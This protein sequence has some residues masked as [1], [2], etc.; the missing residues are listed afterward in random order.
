[1]STGVERSCRGVLSD[2]SLSFR[3]LVSCF[4]NCCP[5]CVYSLDYDNK[6]FS[7][8]SRNSINNG[9]NVNWDWKLN[10][11][12]TYSQP[13]S[14]PSP[15]DF[16]P[17]GDVDDP[18]RRDPHTPHRRNTH[19][20]NTVTK[21]FKK[22][23]ESHTVYTRHVNLGFRVSFGMCLWCDVSTHSVGVRHWD[24]LGTVV[25]WRSITKDTVGNQLDV[26]TS[27]TPAPVE[28]PHHWSQSP[29]ESPHH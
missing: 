29:P 15:P 11:V 16:V 17:Y 27:L 3:V 21:E 24:M 5:Y 6:Q 22:K 18:N 13:S 25:M 26:S 7:Y 1:M 28:S 4:Q 19:L 10:D 2:P 12:I 14:N 23:T 8:W 9:S 20:H